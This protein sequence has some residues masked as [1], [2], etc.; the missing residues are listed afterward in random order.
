VREWLTFLAVV[1]GWALVGRF[2]LELQ[3]AQPWAVA[4]VWLVGLIW[5]IGWAAGSAREADYL[6]KLMGGV[7]GVPVAL[8]AVILLVGY[9][10]S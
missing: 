6:L 1:F 9:V 10:F 8:V 7:I 2:V 5:L 4:L 3:I